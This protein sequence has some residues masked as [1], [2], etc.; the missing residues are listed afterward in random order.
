MWTRCNNILVPSCHATQ[1]NHDDWDTVKL[2][3]RRQ[4]KSRGSG[5]ALT[6]ELFRSN[7]TNKYRID[8]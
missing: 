4:E 1:R 3:D 5:R 6:T 7:S 2:P 8:K